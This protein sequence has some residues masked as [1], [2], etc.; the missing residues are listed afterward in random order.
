MA[1]RPHPP[2]NP[3]RQGGQARSACTH[4][5]PLLLAPPPTHTCQLSNGNTSVLPAPSRPSPAPPP[6]AWVGGWQVCARAGGCR[7]AHKALTG[8]GGGRSSSQPRATLTRSRSVVGMSLHL[9]I[10]LVTMTPPLS[11][12]RSLPPIQPPTHPARWAGRLAVCSAGRG[13]GPAGMAGR[14]GRHCSR[15]VQS[16][17][18][19]RRGGTNERG[20]G[21]GGAARGGGVSGARPGSGEGV[22]VGGGRGGAR[23]MCCA[24][25]T[26]VTC[27]SCRCVCVGGVGWGGGKGVRFK[28]F[29]LTRPRRLRRCPPSPPPLLGRLGPQQKAPRAPRLGE[30]VGVG[31]G[32]AGEGGQAV[33]AGRAGASPPFCMHACPSS[34]RTHLPAPHPPPSPHL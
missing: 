24:C 29:V 34:A 5:P 21:A 15:A 31:W 33:R 27:A 12:L 13:A 26:G 19:A 9:A 4:R 20:R 6:P 14:A 18:T 7:G 32:W 3:S 16:C 2:L 11:A 17:V 22:C 30:R 1:Q 25:T 28:T 8:V 23:E 10:A